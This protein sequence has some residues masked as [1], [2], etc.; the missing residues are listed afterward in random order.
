MNGETDYRGSAVDVSGSQGCR[1]VVTRPG[2]APDQASRA[3]RARDGHWKGTKPPPGSLW[4]WKGALGQVLGGDPFRFRSKTITDQISRLRVTPPLLPV[5]SKELRTWNSSPTPPSPTRGGLQ[6]P[7][8]PQVCSLHGYGDKMSPGPGRTKPGRFGHGGQ[9]ACRICTGISAKN[10]KNQ[11][12]E[13]PPH[14]FTPPYPHSPLE[15]EFS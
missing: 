12:D 15:P 11:Q 1:Q 3:S 4:D 9:N 2:Q 10:K 6:A 14:P 5:L 13:I 8:S 7:R